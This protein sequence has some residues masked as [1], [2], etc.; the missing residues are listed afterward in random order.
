MLSMFQK[1]NMKIW[2]NSDVTLYWNRLKYKFFQI[3][4]ILFNCKL[5]ETWKV[6]FLFLKQNYPECL[7]YGR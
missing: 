2:N 1:Q 4:S 3:I 5:E 6:L 7:R